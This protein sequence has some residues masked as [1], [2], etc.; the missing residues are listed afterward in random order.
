ML[1][2]ENAKPREKIM[3]DLVGKQFLLQEE[4]YTIVDTRNIEGEVMV[5]ASREGGAKGPLRAA[6]RL[7][8]I[9]GKLSDNAAA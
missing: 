1:S 6:F 4:P 9:E 5:Y 8:D 2:I 7:S 3:E